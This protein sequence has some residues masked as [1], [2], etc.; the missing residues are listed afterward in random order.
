MSRF[1]TLC[2]QLRPDGI[3]EIGDRTFVRQLIKTPAEQQPG[4]SRV[5]TRREIPDIDTIGNDAD[6]AFSLQEGLTNCSFVI[7]HHHVNMKQSDTIGALRQ[8]SA[9]PRATRTCATTDCVHWQLASGQEPILYHG[10]STQCQQKERRNIYG[11]NPSV[12]ACTTSNRNRPASR[13]RRF[14]ISLDRN[15]RNS[16][17]S[18]VSKPPTAR[19]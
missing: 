5:W 17:G 10:D 13:S 4:P 7:G 14:T 12:S 9:P 18:P 3:E 16:Y 6:V 19:Q 2:R 8:A 15:H 11:A 1:F